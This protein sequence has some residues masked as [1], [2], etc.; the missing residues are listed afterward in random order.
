MAFPCTAF[1]VC[2]SGW[3]YVRENPGC[4]PG[5]TAWGCPE[6]VSFYL[7]TP[8]WFFFL[9]LQC[10]I[11]WFCSDLPGQESTHLLMHFYVQA[12]WQWRVPSFCSINISFPPVWMQIR[13]VTPGIQMGRVNGLKI[14]K[15]S[16]W[17]WFVRAL[18]KYGAVWLGL[19][20]NHCH[21]KLNK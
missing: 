7:D 17:M 3:I 9:L 11:G 5:S 15:G 20:E 4:W 19:I 21:Y 1:V 8:L 2:I 18:D 6:V 13:N 12:N 10:L 16:Q 14:T